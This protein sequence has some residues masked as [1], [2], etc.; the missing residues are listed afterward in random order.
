[1]KKIDKFK[2]KY[3]P[4]LVGGFF[5]IFFSPIT[6]A[7]CIEDPEKSSIFIVVNIIYFA[8]IAIV[9]YLYSKNTL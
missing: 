8:L 9:Q 7:V 2:N 4:F 5:C 3:F 1:M 6:I